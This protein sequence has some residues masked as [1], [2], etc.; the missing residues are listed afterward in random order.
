MGNC[1]AELVAGSLSSHMMTR[2]GKAA[3]HSP[4]A[5]LSCCLSRNEFPFPVI[6][7]L[8]PSVVR[9]PDPAQQG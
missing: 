3:P 5:T 7:R 2:H 6:L 1:G 9:L 4:H 8:Y